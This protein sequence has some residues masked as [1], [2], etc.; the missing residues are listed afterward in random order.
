MAH[1]SCGNGGLKIVFQFMILLCSHTIYAD[2]LCECVCNLC[3]TNCKQ[4]V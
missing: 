3:E 1:F 2:N 4:G